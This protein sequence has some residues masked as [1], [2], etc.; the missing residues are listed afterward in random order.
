MPYK[1]LRPGEV[2]VSLRDLDPHIYHDIIS[3]ESSWC[4]MSKCQYMKMIIQ[5][6]C[7]DKAFREQLRDDIMLEHER[8]KLL[9]SSVNRT[10]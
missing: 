2:N 1:P 7:K 10:I 3:V 4:K 5:T 8:Q 9:K 6:V